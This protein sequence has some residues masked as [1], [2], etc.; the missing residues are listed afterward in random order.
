[1]AIVNNG[2]KNN[3][4]AGQIPSGY[5]RPT[6]TEFDDFEYERTLSLSIL[7]S[8]VENATPATTMDNIFDD[9]TVGLDKQIDDILAA[10]Y[11]ATASVVAYAELT[12]LTHNFVS[13]SGNAPYLTT[14]PVS[15]LC[16]LKLYVKTV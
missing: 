2:T 7:K 3:L 1:M 4:P 11:L 9:A 13:K 5:T 12:S 8:V 15:Y 10:D 6:V 16:T 14:D